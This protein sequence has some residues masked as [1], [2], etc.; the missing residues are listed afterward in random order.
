MAKRKKRNNHLDYAR[1]DKLYKML[2]NCHSYYSLNYG[3]LSIREV[4][5]TCQLLGHKTVALTDINNTSECFTFLLLAKEYNIHPVVG[6]DFRNGVDQQFVGVAQNH[7]GFCELNEFLSHHQSNKIPIPE[8]AQFNNAITIYPF[9]KAQYFDKLKKSEYT[10]IAPGELNRPVFK[11]YK[12]RFQNKLV[13]LCTSTFRHKKD[14]NAHRLLRAIGENTLL[15]KLEKTQQAKECN[16]YRNVEEISELYEHHSELVQR[17]E[18]LLSSCQFEFEFNKPNNKANFTNSHDDDIQLLRKLSYEGLPY[19]YDFNPFLGK[20]LTSKQQEI[21]N[22]VEN[23]LKVI[24]QYGFS[25]Y[26]LINW[27]MVCY[28]IKK[29]YPHVGR[30]SGANS[31]VA[32]LIRIT[33]VDP[34]ELDLYFER[35]M[36]PF[37]STPPDFDVDF[38]WTDRDDVITYLFEKHGYDKVALLGSYTTYQ[39]K[40]VIRELGKVFGLPSEEIEQLQRGGVADNEYVQL[41][42]KYSSYIAGFPSNLSI[43]SSGILISEKPIHYYS[44]TYLP[45]K[46]YP[47]V[48]F[49]MHIAEDIGLYKYDVL[50]QRGLGKIKDAVTLIEKNHGKKVDIHAMQVIKNDPKV[51]NLLREGDLT[52]CFYVESPAMRMLMTKL[53]AEDYTRLVAASSIIR[54]GVAKSGMMREYILRFQSIERREAA[55]KALPELYDILDETF[56]VMVYQEDVLKVAHYFAGLSLAEADILRRGMSWKFKQRNEFSKIKQR[57]FDNCNR[58][59]LTPGTVQ[60]IWDQIESF[61][62]FAFSKGHSASYAVE[63]FQALYLHAYYPLEYLTATINNGG[64]FYSRELYVHTARMKGAA[65]EL[66]CVN[67]SMAIA[68]IKG[69]RLLLGFA[70]IDGGFE[71]KNVNF[72]LQERHKNGSFTTFRNF[73]ERLPEISLDQLIVLIRLGCFRNIENDK[74]KLLWDAHFLLSKTPKKIKMDSLFELKPQEWKLPELEQNSL[75]I[76]MSE[77]ELLGFPVSYNPFDLLEEKKENLPQTTARELKDKIGKIVSIAG[78]RV[79]V[80]TTKTKNG[81]AMRFGTFIDTKGHW[82]DTVIFP[83]AMARMKH[84]GPGCYLIKGKISEEFGHVSVDVSDLMRYDNKVLE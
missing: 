83:D 31:I 50:S 78:Y 16:K 5:A 1:R 4:L 13:A 43:H 27:D 63:S 68:D 71:S 7:E 54:P 77:I 26:F 2:I 28:S 84:I 37:R 12:E 48:H 34:I 64:G 6:I 47:T 70:F 10:G 25:A 3:C 45:P 55:Q 9:E 80:R 23:E 29:G 79:F 33:N 75:E 73:V 46:N 81:N 17:S 72:M 53:K 49:D 67:E 57:F 18:K 38:S 52:G 21:L 32:Y 65:I 44:T 66:P 74:K 11:Q 62:N 30:G 20:K 69:K 8:R 19:R 40:S 59:R 22:R 60:K 42:Q 58:K 56:G 82:I 14:Y 15:S 41:I 61:A 24:E 76:A 51:K 36:N 35:F 39:R